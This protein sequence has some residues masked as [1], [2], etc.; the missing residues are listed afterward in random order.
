MV[1]VF[2]CS[3]ICSSCAGKESRNGEGNSGNDFRSSLMVSLPYSLANAATADGVLRFSLD[4]GGLDENA[5]LR[6]KSWSSSARS[7]K[8]FRSSVRSLLDAASW[9]MVGSCKPVVIGS[10]IAMS[11]VSPGSMASVVSVG[12][13]R[14]TVSA[15]SASLSATSDSA[16]SV[17]SRFSA[18]SAATVSSASAAWIVSITSTAISTPSSPTAILVVSW[19]S[20]FIVSEEWDFI[21]TFP[22]LVKP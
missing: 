9:R 3:C 19:G 7:F 12:S 17:A 8:S 16:G 15:V 18:E 2:C 13:I 22:A 20:V 14:L 11:V 4:P 1:L 6:N 5:G 10:S 21:V